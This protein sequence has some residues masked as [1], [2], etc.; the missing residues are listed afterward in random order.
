MKEFNHINVLS[1]IGVVIND[2]K[3][4]MVIIPFMSK[5]DLKNVLRSENE[6][7]WYIFVLLH[8][9]SDDNR[10]ANSVTQLNK[11]RYNLLLLPAHPW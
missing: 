5:G 8:W 9:S 3:L 4:P 2:D 1:L 7:C 11:Y 6:V 10:N